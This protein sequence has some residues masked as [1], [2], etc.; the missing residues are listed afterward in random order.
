MLSRIPGHYSLSASRTPVLHIVTTQMSPHRPRVPV[1]VGQG[2]ESPPVENR[3]SSVK[4]WDSKMLCMEGGEGGEGSV[5]VWSWG[6]CVISLWP[7]GVQSFWHIRI[8]PV[9]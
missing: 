9:S 8:L 6:S 3:W 7:F 4:V 1:V 2:A 5:D